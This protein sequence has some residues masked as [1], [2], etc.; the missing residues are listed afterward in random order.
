MNSGGGGGTEILARVD[1]IHDWIVQKVAANSGSGGGGSE[2]DGPSH[3]GGPGGNSCP[4][5][6]RPPG[7]SCGVPRLNRPGTP[8]EKPEQADKWGGLKKSD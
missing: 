5:T 6:S 4:T 3:L 2:A 8:I 1:L 7:S